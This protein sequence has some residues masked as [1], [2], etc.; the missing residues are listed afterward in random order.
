LAGGTADDNPRSLKIRILD[1]KQQMNDE[2]PVRDLLP[3]YSLGILEEGEKNAVRAHLASCASCRAELASFTE[4]TG[5]LAAAAP[6]REPPAG[7]EDRIVRSIA[8]RPHAA[9]ARAVRG[10]HDTRG[11][12]RRT[13]WRA[14]TA[15]AAMCALALGVGNLLQW[16]GVLQAP[17]RGTQSRFTTALLSGTGDARNAYGTIV[18][19]PLDNK[20]VL[21]VTGL[22]RLDARHQYQLWLI[23]DGQRRSG[24]VF[25]PDEEGYGGMLLTVP[26]DFKDFRAF[27]VT[28]EPFGGSTLPTGTRV[29]FGS[30]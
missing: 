6:P 13:P 9:A 25:S 19:D 20:G 15:I 29:L 24:G 8:A 16:T 27:G 1:E 23:R 7:M 26:E 2:H 17:V 5:R 18:L 11:V 30:L 3:G 21:A 28:V 10:P 14:L 12:R 4:V 22:P